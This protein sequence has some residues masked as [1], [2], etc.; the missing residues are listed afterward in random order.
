MRALW[1]VAKVN[2]PHFLYYK[3]DCRNNHPNANILSDSIKKVVSKVE[4]ETDLIK[5]M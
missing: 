4:C 2:Y 1:Y 5:T 3:A